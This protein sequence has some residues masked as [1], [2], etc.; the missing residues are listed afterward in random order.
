MDHARFHGCFCG[1]A[2]EANH[3]PAM[4]R[5]RRAHRASAKVNQDDDAWVRELIARIQACQSNGDVAGNT[6]TSPLH[7]SL[8]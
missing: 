4:N 1:E 2:L 3:G 6:S 7:F 8:W 5:A